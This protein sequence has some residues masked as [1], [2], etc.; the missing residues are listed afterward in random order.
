MLLQHGFGG[1][2][3]N[4]AALKQCEKKVMTVALTV[5]FGVQT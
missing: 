3:K 5:L 4:T 1:T 2:R